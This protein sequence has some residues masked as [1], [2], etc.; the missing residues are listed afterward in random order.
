MTPAEYVR[1]LRVIASVWDGRTDYLADRERRAIAER[2]REVVEDGGAEVNR[3]QLLR[4]R[5]FRRI[6]MTHGARVVRED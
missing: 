6:A 3:L 5:R 4:L 2:A 1:E